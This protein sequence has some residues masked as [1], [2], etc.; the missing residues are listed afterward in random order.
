[1]VES[2]KILSLSLDE[3]R[4]A[5]REILPPDFALHVLDR[6]QLDFAEPR[7]LPPQSRRS[8]R[9]GDSMNKPFL[10]LLQQCRDYVNHA[11]NSSLKLKEIVAFEIGNVSALYRLVE[12][13]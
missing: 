8:A 4:N 7:I 2:T 9:K 1:M 13:F 6:P 5:V 12:P 10:P 11:R 3:W